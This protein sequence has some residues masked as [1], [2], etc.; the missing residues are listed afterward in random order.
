M[1]HS[2]YVGIKTLMRREINRII[3]IWTQTLLPP[4]I[5]M[6][7][8]FIIFGNLIG[9]RIG[10]MDGFDYM[11][12]IVPGLVM[13]AVITSSYGNMVSSFFG[14]KFAKHIEELLISP[15]PNWAIL[16]GYVGGCLFRGI[17]VGIIVIAISWFFT[18]I[19]IH[20]IWIVISTVV[21]T[22]IVFSLAGFINAAFAK[23]FDDIAIIPTFILTPLT[24]LGGVFYSISLLPEFWQGVSKINPVLYMVNTFRYG[25]L[26]VSDINI[27]AA[28]GLILTFVAILGG[29]SLLILHKGWGLR[30]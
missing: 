13:M 25:F 29:F 4:A 18:E 8:Y 28:Y 27:Y 1:S 11:S 20:N 6:T 22:S 2:T 3:R 14:A 16:V 5:T 24:Y 19:Q 23:K 10:E 21:L 15:M 17:S 12:F 26:G 7:L 30:S 9:S